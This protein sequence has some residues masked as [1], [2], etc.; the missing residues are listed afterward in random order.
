MYDQED[1]LKISYEPEKKTKANSSEISS[2]EDDCANCDKAR[3]PNSKLRSLIPDDFQ[4]MIS[5]LKYLFFFISLPSPS[6]WTKFY[7]YWIQRDKL[8]TYFLVKKLPIATDIF[9]EIKREIL[10]CM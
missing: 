3:I 6:P 8:H 7:R 5:K 2:D 9:A 1:P 10:I 4:V